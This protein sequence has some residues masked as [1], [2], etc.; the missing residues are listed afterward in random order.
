MTNLSGQT[1]LNRY[2][3]DTFIGRG[4]MADVYKVWDKELMS[5]LAMK[6]LHQDIATDKIFLRRF[7]REAATLA[8]LQHPNIVR[9]YGFEQVGRLAFML[10]DFIDGESLKLK[11]FDADQPF[12]IERITEIIH[13]VIGALQYAHNQGM[14]HC[15]LK[16]A[17]IMIN[18]NNKVFLTDFGIA[19]MT[20]AATATMVG[21]GTPAY[22]APEQA[23]GLDPTPKTDIYA[24]GV[25][26][27]EML[28]GGE[29]P[30]TGEQART[31][32]STS[33]KVRW[34]Q[35]NLKPPSPRKW[36]PN[37]SPALE[38]VVLKCLAKEPEGRYGNSIDLLNAFIKTF[39]GEKSTEITNRNV[40]L[41]IEKIKPA[42]QGE[43]FLS[44]ES[45]PV[46]DGRIETS[47]RRNLIPWF[48]VGGLIIIVALLAF[49]LYDRDSQTGIF[50]IASRNDKSPTFTVIDPL[51]SHTPTNS[52]TPP[53][54]YT[55]T[56]TV[57]PSPTLTQSNT[58]VP[59]TTTKTSIKTL[60]PT[61]TPK[62]EI[63]FSRY[64]Y[65]DKRLYSVFLPG[66]TTCQASYER[67]KGDRG[68]N[69]WISGTDESDIYCHLQ[70]SL[71]G[72]KVCKF[73][74]SFGG[75]YKVGTSSYGTECRLTIRCQSPG[76]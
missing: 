52:D 49:M 4:G 45:E 15:D 44:I 10:M 35:I 2:H 25:V 57:T 69:V 48:A 59:P 17:N 56:P 46:P 40:N 28:T 12:S 65:P 60:T 38:A 9:F 66:N 8:K 24:L 63:F 7:R 31:T 42:S 74:T 5:F 1:L 76:N 21:M 16:P 61:I 54:I 36:N 64:I 43:P 23:R 32:G 62:S 41:L 37:V 75:N 14:V 70:S 19:R 50:Q 30:F 58:P 47:S 6:L 51:V 20:D 18:E 29:R 53:P 72:I 22:M 71:S 68:C 39:D 26:L 55:M 11:I 73:E 33:E 67:V 13:P 3:V 34:E 27:F